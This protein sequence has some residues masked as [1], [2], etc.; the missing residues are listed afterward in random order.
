M[1]TRED[2]AKRLP[3]LLLTCCLSML[4]V[5]CQVG[6]VVDMADAAQQGTAQ[7]AKVD[8]RIPVRVVAATGGTFPLRTITNGSVAASRKAALHLRSGERIEEVTVTEGQYVEAGQLLCRQDEQALQLD[9]QRANTKRAETWLRLSEL[10]IEQG[11]D[12]GDTL[13]VPSQKLQSLKIKSGYRSALDEWAMAAYKMEQARLYAPF[14][15]IITRVKARQWEDGRPGEVFCTLIDQASFEV[16]F[17]VLEKD[18][19]KISRGQMV[20]FEPLAKPGTLYEAR[21]AVVDPVIDEHGL[22]T[23]RAR[24]GNSRRQLIEGMKVKVLIE[25]PVPG[26]VIVPK[27]ALVLR[28]NRQVIFTADQEAGLAKWHYVEVGYENDE[29]L[30]VTSGLSVG[31]LVIVEGNL[32]LAH[33]ASL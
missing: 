10:L 14:G 4:Y 17:T 12:A 8:T 9:L 25:H 15:G 5:S 28:S 30:A 23:V 2:M 31:D 26:M 20:Q 3:A 11:G 33:D 22:L 7:M 19:A 16:V 27:E 29:A 21:I 18:A 13:S 24:P 1:K 6:A 32:N